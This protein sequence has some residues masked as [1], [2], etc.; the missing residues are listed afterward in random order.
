[1]PSKDPPSDPAEIL[2]GADGRHRGA[3]LGCRVLQDGTERVFADLNALKAAVE[4]GEVDDSAR[5]KLPGD[6]SWSRVGKHPALN[7]VEDDPWA[8]WEAMHEGDPV[9]DPPTDPGEDDDLVSLPLD[10]LTE[11]PTDEPIAELPTEAVRVLPSGTRKDGRFVIEG[12]KKASRRNRPPATDRPANPFLASAG[13][14][15]V[16]GAAISGAG[17]TEQHGLAAELPTEAVEAD[18]PSN[19]IAFPSPTGPVTL[20]PHALAPL[21]AESFMELP[22]LQVKPKPEPRTGPRWQMLVLVGFVAF[23][24]VG[25]VHAWVR[26]VATQTFVPRLP[27]RTAAV[28]AAPEQPEPQQAPEVAADPP[29]TDSSAVDELTRLDQDLR[30]RMRSEP[31]KV[32]KKGDLESALYVDLSR[33]NLSE[34][35]VDAVIT[36]WGGKMRDIPKSA[37]IQVGF[38]SRPG[39]LDRE[40][41]AVGLIVGRYTS[42]YELDLPRL[43]VLLD[44]GDDGLRRW[45]I[46]PAQARNYYIRRSDLPTFLT[47]MR[48]AG[49]R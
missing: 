30:S 24:L 14:P 21:H 45:P 12:P 48:T 49:G 28:A 7:V 34:L 15:S 4:R 1:M 23:A 27:P 39:E 18:A 8:V 20:G 25:V 10:A 29:P 36:A 2:D 9:V 19:V 31:G 3:S 22:A 26:Y 44:T 40:L 42:V 17:S 41:A 46:D 32:R 43:E 38:R 33:M 35:K 5:V 47:N 6:D 11:E 16:R 37:E 13:E